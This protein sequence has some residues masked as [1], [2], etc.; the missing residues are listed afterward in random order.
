MTIFR[1]RLLP[2]CL[3]ACALAAAVPSAGAA[4]ENRLAGKA[5]APLDLQ[6]DLPTEAAKAIKRLDLQQALPREEPEE[7]WRLDIPPKLIWA[8]LIAGAVLLV[9]M[10]GP[11]LLAT[12][13]FSRRPGYG[14][15]DFAAPAGGTKPAEILAAPDELARQGRFGEA[16]H[17]L[18]LR[19]LADLR[20]R[21]GERFADSMTSREI[22]RSTR[23]SLEGRALLREIVARVELTYFG[24]HPAGPA[25]YQACRDCFAALADALGREAPRRPAAA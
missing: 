18:L 5:I 25:D 7:G 1:P 15:A 12:L 23:L 2:G 13:P 8:I 19:C 20:E 16:M 21:L 3:V 9:V 4:D 11:E 14:D 6:R 10:F 24:D 22:L 17:V